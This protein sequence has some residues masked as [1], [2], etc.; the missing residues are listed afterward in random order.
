MVYVIVFLFELIV[1]F[2]LSRRVHKVLGKTLHRIIKSK[3]VSIYVLSVLFFPGTLV[4]EMAH[5]LAALFTG[6]PVGN[7]QLV[8]EIE[9]DS[10]RLG[11]VQI[12]RT[13][14][15]RR[16]I[17][18]TAPF[19][20]G[21]TLIL[22]LT[23]FSITNYSH[24][25]YFLIFSSY[26]IFAITNTMFIS[27]KDLEGVWGFLILAAVLIIVGILLG[28]SIDVS[29]SETSRLAQSAKSSS[30]YLIFPIFV[31]LLLVLGLRKV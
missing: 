18:S 8:P 23:Y 7:M 9:E 10:I 26:L 25:S 13:D 2:F 16:F 11:S 12:A 30:Y 15:V 4:H 6:V 28:V 27:S 24:N 29:I 31:D 1:L 17:V 20:V 21:T 5:F 3:R 22:F 19:F 14:P